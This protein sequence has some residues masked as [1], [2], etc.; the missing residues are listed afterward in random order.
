VDEMRFQLTRGDAV[1]WLRTLPDESIDLVVT[2]PPYESLEKHRAIG[3]TTRLKHSKASS[4]DWFEIFPNARFEELF[5]EI[6]R[7]LKKNTHFYLFCDPETMF[8]AKPL[9]E[10]A[11]FKFWKP[12][13]WDK[14]LGPDTLVWTERGAIR[15][16]DIEAGDRVALPEGG[17]TPVR[18]TRRTRSDALK[19]LLSDGT[20]IIA[21][22]E[23]R[24]VRQSGEQTEARWLRVGDALC[25]RPVRE[26]ERDQLR[27]EDVIPAED[28]VYELPNLAECLWCNEPFPS[29]R[30]ASAHQSRHCEVALSKDAMAQSLGITPRRLRRWMSQARLPRSWAKQLGLESKLGPRV[31]CHLQNDLEVWYPRTIAM[32]FELGKFVGLFAAEGSWNTC[33]GISFAFHAN[34][35]HLHNHVARFVRSLG[36]HAQVKPD[37]NKCYVLVNFR[38]A[39]HLVNYFIGGEDSRTKYFKPSVYGAND[40]FRRGVVAGMVEGDG[41]WSH[42]EQRETYVSA[43]PDLAYFIRREIE[44]NGRVA[45]LH[46]FENDHAG[47]WNVRWDPMRAS[48][49]VC[50]IGIEE[51]G[52][53]DLVDI[54]VE[55]RDELF[56]LANGVVTHNCNIG[57]GYHYRARYECILFFEKG[58]RKLNDLGTADIIEQPR[59]NGGYPAE[60]PPQV[61]SV[62]IGQSTEPGALVIDPFMGSGST[63]VAAVGLGRN[64]MGNDLCEEAMQITRQRL[65][66]A[67]AKEPLLAAPEISPHAQ[68]GLQM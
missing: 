29:F 34:E 58:K 1:A 27:F 52:V 16:A 44:A 2:D 3:T 54:S 43:S 39:E 64:F 4:N 36:I 48:E 31:Q 30:A 49:P 5:G 67:G 38:I 10:K 37:G 12:L 56:L 32:D 63:G 6:Y 60:K 11:G 33:S 42:E 47:G 8:V 15:I 17:T 59:I 35:K 25:T 45:R 13:I 62:L 65:L 20:E 51:C 50:V 55:D 24:F 28:A 41:H 21:S 53:Q 22:K 57:M 66:E 40:E 18:A 19:L 9:G 23:H 46:R 68:L 14:C 26:H 61:A 7:V